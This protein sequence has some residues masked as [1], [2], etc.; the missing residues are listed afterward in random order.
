MV[1]TSSGTT[2]AGQAVLPCLLFLGVWG[3]R[4]EEAA[5]VLPSG[6]AEPRAGE[7]AV[8]DHTLLSRPAPWICFRVSFST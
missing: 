7:Q 8:L 5:A 3:L 2:L 6:R 4:S 1:G